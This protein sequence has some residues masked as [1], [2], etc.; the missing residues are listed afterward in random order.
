MAYRV[1]TG[2]VISQASDRQ[3]WGPAHS[4]CS[5]TMN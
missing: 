5:L 2:Q 4:K 1:H 3:A